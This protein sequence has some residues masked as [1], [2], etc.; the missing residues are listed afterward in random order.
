VATQPRGPRTFKGALVSIGLVDPVPAVI[1]FQYNPHSLKRSLKPLM[2]GGSEGDRSQ[3]VRFTSAPTQTISVEIEFD[4]TDALEA[5]DPI[6]LQYGIG[7]DLA[8]IE[9]LAY[10]SLSDVATDTTL[11]A[12]GT[13][14]IAPMTAPRTLFV[15][16]SNRVLPVRIESCSVSEEEFDPRLNPIRATVSLEMRVL[17]YSD[18]SVTDPDYAQFAAYQSQLVA[19]SS[20]ALSSSTGLLGTTVL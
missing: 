4:A 8:A 9:L 11:L 19:M 16:G 7:P 18:V 10:P 6:A 12:V 15:W 13:I 1:Y 3:A 2:A 5:A 20:S 17:T 14:E